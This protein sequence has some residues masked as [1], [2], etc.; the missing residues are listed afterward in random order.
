[1]RRIGEAVREH[2]RVERASTIIE[3]AALHEAP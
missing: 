1:M 2:R 3:E